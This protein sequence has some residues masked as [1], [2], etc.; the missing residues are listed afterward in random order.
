VAG[1]AIAGTGEVL[2]LGD[3]GIVGGLRHGGS[4]QKREYREAG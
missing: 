1:D 2:T 4:D 3:E